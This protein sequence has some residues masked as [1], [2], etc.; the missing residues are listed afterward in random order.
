VS[1]V[2]L[3]PEPTDVAPERTSKPEMMTKVEV[4]ELM[5]K[6]VDETVEIQIVHGKLLEQARWAH[7]KEDPD[8]QVLRG[9]KIFVALWTVM[10]NR[11]NPQKIQLGINELTNNMWDLMHTEQHK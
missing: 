8:I 5:V 3:A 6:F 10:D 1:L 2:P 11:S 7:P 4:R 9:R